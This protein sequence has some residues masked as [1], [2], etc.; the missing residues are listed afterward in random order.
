[1]DAKQS[2]PRDI[3]FTVGEVKSELTSGTQVEL[4]PATG[5]WTQ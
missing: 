1:M 3:P 2:K 5:M 4:A